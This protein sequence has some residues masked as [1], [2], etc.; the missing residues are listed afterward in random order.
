VTG[1]GEKMTKIEYMGGSELYKSTDLEVGQEVEEIVQTYHLAT[2]EQDNG[3]DQDKWVLDF[4][5]GKALVLNATN[6][7][8]LLD[9]GYTDF[10]DLIATKVRIRKE[11]R[12]VETSKGKREFVGLF[13][14]SVRSE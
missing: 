6:T 3:K 7:K 10:E 13:I 8:F 4:V 1:I 2:F 14:V 9:A 5:S 12:K 11:V